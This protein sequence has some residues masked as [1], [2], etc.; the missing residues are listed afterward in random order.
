M[1]DFFARGQNVLLMLE[2]AQSDYFNFF[3]YI[4]RFW[5]HKKAHIFLI[6]HGKFHSRKVFCSEDFN[7]NASSY[8]SHNQAYT[9]RYDRQLQCTKLLRTS[10]RLDQFRWNF[11][12]IFSDSNN[13]FLWRKSEDIN[14][15]SLFPKF[16][17]I[18]VLHF[19]VM[20]DLVCFIAPIDY[21]VELKSRV[22]E[23]SVTI[24]LI[25][26]WNDFNLIPLRKCAS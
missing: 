20:H 9:V 18:P 4:W 22:R 11:K 17:L 25:S 2:G 23:F 12:E 8:G 26:Y 15:K 19:Q 24:A 14:K 7:E 16:Q 6:T 5:Y 10:K 13:I 3:P 1:V 21:C